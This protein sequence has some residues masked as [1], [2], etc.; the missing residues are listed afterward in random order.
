MH[1]KCNAPKQNNGKPQKFNKIK[2]SEFCLISTRA[3]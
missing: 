2:N 3:D 1:S